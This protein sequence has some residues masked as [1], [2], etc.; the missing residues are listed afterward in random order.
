MGYTL[1]FSHNCA[2]E[3]SGWDKLR[4]PLATRGSGPSSDVAIENW[5]TLLF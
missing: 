4:H 2:L 3:H 5:V 1:G